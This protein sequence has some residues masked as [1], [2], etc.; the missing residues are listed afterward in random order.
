MGLV[1]LGFFF[2][3]WWVENLSLL[4]SRVVWHLHLGDTE[5][6]LEVRPGKVFVWLCGNK[7]LS[8][9][10]V[11]VKI[12]LIMAE[13]IWVGKETDSIINLNYYLAPCVALLISKAVIY[14]HVPT[15]V[16]NET[17][18]FIPV[19]E[20]VIWSEDCKVP[21]GKFWICNI[22]IYKLLQKN[23]HSWIW[24]IW[25]PHHQPNSSDDLQSPQF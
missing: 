7:K 6:P 2:Q 25:M 12:Y 8:V 5:T 16:I 4:T 20:D 1:F 22:G 23:T 21:W 9:T 19:E 10:R 14:I 3:N 13:N 17:L 11:E 24:K 15:L 18:N